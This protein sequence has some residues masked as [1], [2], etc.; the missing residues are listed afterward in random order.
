MLEAHMDEL[1]G[2]VRRVTPE[3]FLSIEMLGSSGSIRRYIGAY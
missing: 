3:G 1:G 2:V